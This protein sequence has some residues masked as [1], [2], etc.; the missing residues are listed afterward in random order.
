MPPTSLPASIESTVGPVPLGPVPADTAAV[1]HPPP[2]QPVD[3][4]SGQS[5]LTTDATRRHAR[6]TIRVLHLVN[7]EHFSG[8]E[9]VQSHLGNRLP[10]CGVEADFAC[11]KP[12]RFAEQLEE[13][14]GDWGL[15]HRTRMSNRFDLRVVRQIRDLVD[16]HGYQLLHAHTPRTALVAAMASRF[17]GVPWV[18]HVH[19]PA[20][21]DSERPILNRINATI[22]RASLRGADHLIA[23]SQSLQQ[24]C[25]AGGIESHRVS[26]VHNGVPA[27]RP[28]RSTFPKPGGHWTLGMIALMRPRKGLEVALEALAEIRRRGHEVTLRCIGPFETESYRQEIRSRSEAL[29]LSGVVQW[30][31]FTRDVA[32]ALSKLDAMILPSLYGEGLPMVVLESMAAGT[33]V[34]ATRVEGTPEAITDGVEGLMAEAGDPRSL[35]DKIE[36][37]L[38]GDHDWT[39]MSEAAARR[40]AA[41]FSDLAM[42]VGVAKVYRRLID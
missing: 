37:L 13:R 5:T 16:W 15:C 24:D 25:L 4:P 38:M 2:D 9:R 40:H 23:V 26:V 22:E 12:G 14:N 3:S 6:E 28:P 31:G 10:E 30:S 21:R 35:A 41:E 11:L 34:I 27:V 7:G 29:A 8:A 17:C 32:A 19:S 39:A 42:A 20:S 36:Q 1:V 18:Y 33:P